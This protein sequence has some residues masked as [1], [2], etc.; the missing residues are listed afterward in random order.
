MKDS[1]SWNTKQGSSASSALIAREKVKS[2]ILEE[3]NL[4]IKLLE[5]EIPA[6]PTSER[7]ERLEKRLE[8]SMAEWFTNIERA[9]DQ[10]A[11]AQIYYANVE[12][13]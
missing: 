11:L 10:D 1:G 3:I 9:I 2:S 13:E 12:Q 7:N 4:T 8:R 5:S 6:N